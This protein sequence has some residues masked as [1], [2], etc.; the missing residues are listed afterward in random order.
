M[1]DGTVTSAFASVLIAVNPVN[2]APVA[3]NNTYQ[4]PEETALA[5]PLRPLGVL[6][7]DT[8]VD[9]LQ[10]SLTAELVGGPGHGALT[11]NA[12]G[13]FTY[14]PGTD[15]AGQ[16]TFTYRAV[17]PHGAVSNAATV[18][19]T[20]QD[21]NDTPVAADA[22]F[23]TNEDEPLAGTLAASDVDGDL[24]SFS[25]VGAPINGVVELL[26]PDAFTYTPDPNF[27]G[28][29]SFTF[30][31]NDGDL[32]SNV[33]TVF[34][35]IAAVNDAPVAMGNLFALDED[36]VLTIQAPGVL[37]NDTDVDSAPLMA[38]LASGTQHGLLTF[39]ANGSFT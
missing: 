9:D 3:V 33:A 23:E 24:L 30:K 22:T 28:T 31:A 19:L 39:N 10:G 4:T 18:T 5:I 1:S 17:D 14:T 6:G 13:T 7:N 32:D 16:D 11:F 8:D 21:V 37:G 34:I 26:A 20:V 29:D 36:T 15:F 38:M 2:D 25:L 27:F 35:T 12:N